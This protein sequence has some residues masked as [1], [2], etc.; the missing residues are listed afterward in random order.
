MKV[1][2]C[3]YCAGCE[4]E[5]VCD[6]ACSAT[7]RTNTSEGINLNVNGMFGD[8]IIKTEDFMSCKVT[9]PLN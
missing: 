1:A 2:N 9:V 4:V 5:I 8:F 3:Y 6:G 7:R